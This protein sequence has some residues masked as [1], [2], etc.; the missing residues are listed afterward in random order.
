MRTTGIL[1]VPYTFCVSSEGRNTF[2]E[3]I[4]VAILSELEGC[5]DEG[6]EL[7]T[8]TVELEGSV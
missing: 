1:P 8:F 6:I 4:L 2:L 5:K 7:E 3:K